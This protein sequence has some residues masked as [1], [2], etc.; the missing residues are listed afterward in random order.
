MYCHKCGNQISDGSAFCPKCG[1]KLIA[2]DAAQ[3][4]AASTPARQTQPPICN[5][6]SDTP[7]K[8][9]SNKL[10]I[11]LG[12]VALAF[13]VIIM[14]VSTD[15]DA[16]K[17]VTSDPEGS[18]ATGTTESSVYGDSDITY[19][20]EFSERYTQGYEPTVMLYQ[21]G[22][23]N[24]Y[25]NFSEGMDFYNGTYTVY[26]DNYIF[27][28][29]KTE[30]DFEFIMRRSDDTLIYENE[31]SLGMT[32]EGAVFSLSDTPPKSIIDASNYEETYE[33][34]EPF[35][36]EAEDEPYAPTAQMDSAL[37]GRWR[38]SDG[39]SITLDEY[40]GAQTS[41]DLRPWWALG[42]STALSWKALNG[43]L[44][45]A[46]NYAV[47]LKYRYYENVTNDL[48][49][50]DQLKVGGGSFVRHKDTVGN[51]IIGEWTDDSKP[52]EA[53]PYFIF[54]ENGTGIWKA[55]V[56]MM[57]RTDDEKMY[58]YYNSY[59]TYDYYVFGDML[60]LFFSDGSK[61]FTKVGN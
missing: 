4:A 28:V 51:G 6:P 53:V 37:F 13:V 27:R 45:L 42:K 10:L 24:F 56:P 54:Q 31:S 49:T 21:D 44:E 29:A 46:T 30:F 3:Q 9:K 16:V 7:L 35:E 39:T 57:W 60:E 1:A 36:Y 23:F 40:G 25:A 26:E 12:V 59:S 34:E 17:P 20:V 22:R 61:I 58:M 14:A 47:E 2:N 11:I 38:A 18:S 50:Y 15:Y 33:G 19:F 5:V 32:R 55:D 41:M 8:R 52:S 48:G 43:Q